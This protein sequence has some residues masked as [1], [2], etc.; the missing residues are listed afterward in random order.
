MT[1]HANGNSTNRPALI[2]FGKRGAKRPH[3]A[4]FR[5][6]NANVAQWVAAYLGFSVV[7]V[8]SAP[9]RNL[10]KLL[11]EWQFE[12]DGPPI[13]PIV[14]QEVLEQLDEL[15]ADSVAFEEAHTGLPATAMAKPEPGTAHGD[16]KARQVARSLWDELTI[17][18][19]VL[20]PELDR[21]GDPEDWYSA[22]ILALHEGA[23][24]LRWCDYPEQGLAK[25]ERHH[26]ALPYP[27]D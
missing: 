6:A 3:A 5:A 7:P 4:W 2:V 14:K 24:I 19:V 22:V 1:K 27:A 20:A 25:R 15:A 21:K 23:Y 16:A 12:R 10:A 26:I 11:T 9:A 8:D 17:G 13:L 18:R